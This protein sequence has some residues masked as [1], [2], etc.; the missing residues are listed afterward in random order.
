MIHISKRVLLHASTNW[1]VKLFTLSLSGHSHQLFH[2]SA[3]FGTHFQLE[4]LVLDLEQRRES[5]R[6]S[7]ASHPCRGWPG[8]AI[9]FAAFA[10]LLVAGTFS[11]AVVWLRPRG[12]DQKTCRTQWNDW[13]LFGSLWWAGDWR[14]AEGSIGHSH[15][16]TLCSN[17]V[18]E[19]S[20]GHQRSKI[21]ER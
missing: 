14:H 1:L 16:H 19:M 2:T 13:V 17:T 9:A 21:R 4:A 11:L 3:V 10:N 7:S 6:I 5:L 20:V 18:R 15:G 8:G 12:G